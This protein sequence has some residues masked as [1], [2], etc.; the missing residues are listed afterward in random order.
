LNEARKIAVSYKTKIIGANLA[1]GS[2]RGI[3]TFIPI[4]YCFDNTGDAI[5]VSKNDVQTRILDIRAKTHS[6]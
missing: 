6:A 4:A 5:F 2:F 3:D 1:D